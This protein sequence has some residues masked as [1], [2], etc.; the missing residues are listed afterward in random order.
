MKG[1]GKTLVSQDV[2]FS[3]AF[4]GTRNGRKVSSEPRD[5]V[6][7]VWQEQGAHIRRH[8][9]GVSLALLDLKIPEAFP[10]QP[11]SGSSPLFPE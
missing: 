11:G 7:Q 8:P 3:M 9:G 10:D 2:L 5:R 6:C 1:C 4:L